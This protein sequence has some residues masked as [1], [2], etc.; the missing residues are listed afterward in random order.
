MEVSDLGKLAEKKCFKL[1]FEGFK[2]KKQAQVSCTIYLSVCEGHKCQ[3]RP[4]P[5]SA[6]IRSPSSSRLAM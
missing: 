2:S 5:L 4:E 6:L 3:Q 1:S